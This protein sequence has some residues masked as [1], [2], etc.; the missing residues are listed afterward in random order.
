MLFIKYIINLLFNNKKKLVE[1]NFNQ[2]D[3]IEYVDPHFKLEKLTGLILERNKDTYLI[4]WYGYY[5]E[6]AYQT[7]DIIDQRSKILVTS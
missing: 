7:K 1:K 6:V 2:G 4:K 3:I 5:S